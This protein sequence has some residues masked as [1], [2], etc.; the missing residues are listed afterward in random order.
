[1]DTGQEVSAEL[2]IACGDATKVFEFIEEALDQIA[3]AIKSEIAVARCLSVG[4][5]WNDRGDVSPVE[6]VDERVS[7]VRLVAEQSLRFNTI[8]QRLRAGKIVRLTGC[9]HQL[10]RI[11]QGVD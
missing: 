3:F 2:I 9:Q 6:S 4:L 11:A 8:E 5:G 7:I 10:D 1:M